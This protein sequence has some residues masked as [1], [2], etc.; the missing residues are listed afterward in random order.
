M[1]SKTKP[2]SKSKRRTNSKPKRSRRARPKSRARSKPKRRRNPRRRSVSR[3]RPKSTR[4]RRNP[5]VTVSAGPKEIGAFAGTFVG[6]DYIAAVA[7]DVASR[8][9]LP[10]SALKAGLGIGAAFLLSKTKWGRK[11]R[12]V[13]L[14]IGGAGLAQGLSTLSS[15]IVNKAPKPEKPLIN[16]SKSKATTDVDALASELD[17]REGVGEL[18]YSRS[19]VGELDYSRGGVAGIAEDVAAVG[20]PSHWDAEGLPAYMPAHWA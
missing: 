6:L 2:K 10:G 5:R 9:G 4:R 20:L 7:L 19:G 8:V 16:L 3:R 1:A 15:Y 13:C 12:G 18:D 11:N 17:N 14:A